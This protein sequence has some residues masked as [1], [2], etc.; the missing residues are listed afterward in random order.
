MASPVRPEGTPPGGSPPRGPRRAALR[1]RRRHRRRTVGVVAA[2]CALA[3]VVAAAIGALL[4]ARTASVA[5]EVAPGGASRPQRD[6]VST[7]LLIGTNEG[8]RPASASVLWLAI[9]AYDA[10]RERG[11]ILY[12]PAHVAAE[13]P[14][15]GLQGLGDAF[16]SAGIPLLLVSAEN[17]L[18]VD[19]DHYLELSRQDARVL[20]HATGPLTVDVPAD[21]RVGLGRDRARLIFS[22]GDQRL[23]AT[24]LERLLYTAGLDGDDAE[25]G[26][27]HLAFWDA[28]LERFED[29][30]EGLGRAVRRAGGSLRESDRR[31]AQLGRLFR[32]L[33]ELDPQR[34]TLAVLPVEQVG[35]GGEEL[36]RVD[37]SEARELLDLTIGPTRARDEERVQVLN[38]NGAPGIG[39]AIARRLVGHGFKI[40]LSGNAPRL[41]YPRTRIVTYDSSAAGLAAARRAR[42]LIGLGVVQVSAQPQGIVDLTVVVGKD[43]LRNR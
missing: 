22:E 34:R 1:E 19:I 5:P 11:G 33:A 8:R 40:I 26:S 35:T 15:R 37:Q 41:D 16:S 13:V 23:P 4:D 28:L 25:L 14:G 3:A 10:S 32:H 31:P 17:L 43:F 2:S 9:A 21:V 39:Q 27:R 7:T 6:A 36:Y 42:A 38:G 30:P 18:D 24:F 12:V 29:A 20:F